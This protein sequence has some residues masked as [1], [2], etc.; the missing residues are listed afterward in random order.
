MGTGGVE[1]QII[2]HVVG[3]RAVSNCSSLRR[4]AP[5]PCRDSGLDHVGNRCRR[6]QERRDE[7]LVGTPGTTRRIRLPD[8]GG[9]RRLARGTVR[10]QGRS[11]VQPRRSLD[12]QPA[13]AVYDCINSALIETKATVSQTRAVICRRSGPQQEPDV[14]VAAIISGTAV[15]RSPSPATGWRAASPASRARNT[16]TCASAWRPASS[17]FEPGRGPGGPE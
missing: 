8:Q 15:C 11:T 5:A 14:G 6:L 2:L 13:S 7:R 17:P 10:P 1:L 4:R 16:S 12:S 3:E 9:P